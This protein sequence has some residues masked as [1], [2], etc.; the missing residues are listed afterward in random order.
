MVSRPRRFGKSYAA[1]SISAFYS[2]GCDSRALFEGLEVSRREG[3][4]EHLN[5]YNVVRLDMTAVMQVAEGSDVARKATEVLMPELRGLA[6]GAGANAAG[7]GDLLASALWDAVQATDRKFVFVIDEWDAPYRLAQDDKAAQDAYAEW[8][9]GLFKNA[10]LTAEVVAGAYMT[11]IL[12]IK[13]YAHQSA[14]SDFDEHT[15]VD[16]AQYAPYAGF[17]Q[18]EVDALCARHGLDPD[19]ARRWYDGYDLPT[20]D[21]RTGSRA[22]SPSTLP[23]R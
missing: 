14:V 2:C 15:M 6:P 17:T 4:D 11:G 7:E 19:D 10:S 20:F 3:W 16:P 18:A 22:T 13:K 23:T 1:Q 8:L 5:K 21:Q 12:P 9:R